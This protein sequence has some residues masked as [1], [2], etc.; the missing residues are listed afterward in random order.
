M[1]N[2]FQFTQSEYKQ[3][4]KPNSES[5]LFKIEV[6]TLL[7]T[8][9]CIG[10]AEVTNRKKDFSDIIFDLFYKPNNNFLLCQLLGIKKPQKNLRLI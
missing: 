8:Q 9:M 3:I 2:N 10:L 7:P 4:S 6:K 1:L 5:D